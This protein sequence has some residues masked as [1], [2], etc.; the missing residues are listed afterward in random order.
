MLRARSDL[1]GLATRRGLEAGVESSALY[2]R[3]LLVAA[4]ALP[5]LVS[6]SASTAAGAPKTSPC[7]TVTR[8]V[9]H[10]TKRVRVCTP[11]DLSISLTV[12]PQPVTEGNEVVAKVLIQDRGPGAAP[13]P[14]VRISIP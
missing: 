10:K 11:A 7:H 13:K 9:G 1:A 14:S 2:V 8:H 5:V 12:S 6:A 3:A 4:V